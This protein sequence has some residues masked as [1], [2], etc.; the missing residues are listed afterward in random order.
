MG[1]KVTFAADDGLETVDLDDLDP[2]VVDRIAI[3]CRCS[4]FECVDEP[5]GSDDRMWAVLDAAAAHVGLGT[6]ERSEDVRSMFGE[7]P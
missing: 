7:S 1:I 5:A 2:E 3:A 4:P 6:V